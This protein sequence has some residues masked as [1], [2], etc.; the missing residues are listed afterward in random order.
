MEQAEQQQELS[1]RTSGG[2]GECTDQPHLADQPTGNTPT[3][4]HG[5]LAPPLSGSNGT[6][7]GSKGG[8]TTD[9]SLGSEFLVN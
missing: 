5:Q 2:S 8:F 6:S 7:S 1:H 4:C 9:N 3:A